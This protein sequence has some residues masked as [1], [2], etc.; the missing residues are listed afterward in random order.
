ML[1][2]L[3]TVDYLSAHSPPPRQT[4]VRPKQQQVGSVKIRNVAYNVTLSRD[5]LDGH[6]RFYLSL[7]L[8][9]PGMSHKPMKIS[10]ILAEV[11]DTGVYIR[12]AE[13]VPS[14]RGG[15][16]GVATLTLFKMIISSTLTKIDVIGTRHIDKPVLAHTLLKAGFVP[17]STHFPVFITPSEGGCGVIICHENRTYDLRSH[18]SSVF[19]RSQNAVIGIRPEEGGGR[20]KWRRTHVFTNYNF[21][22]ANESR[23]DFGSGLTDVKLSAHRVLAF[24]ADVEDAWE[25]I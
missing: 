17:A 2:P 15:G 24:F 12:G 19:L 3:R 8:P 21:D 16:V 22:Y 10:R 6:R 20:E 13:T 4:S 5:A 1:T 9:R 11:E 7:T 23:N 18:F 14:K 25:C